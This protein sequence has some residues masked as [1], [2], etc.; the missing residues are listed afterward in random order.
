MALNIKKSGTDQVSRNGK[1]LEITLRK[2]QREIDK[3]GGMDS[4]R[5]TALAWHL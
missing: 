4:Q 3:L 2:K 5:Q 1:L